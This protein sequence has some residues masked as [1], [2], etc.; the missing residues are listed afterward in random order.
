[1]AS[2]C[3]TLLLL[4]KEMKHGSVVPHIVST[5]WQFHTRN[6]ADDPLDGIGGATQASLR[7]VDCGWRHIQDRNILIAASEQVVHQ[8]RF[9]STNINDGNGA[10]WRNSLYNFE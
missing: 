2:V 6:V 4:G 9:P 7:H 3:G 5:R 8:R 1:L 10:V